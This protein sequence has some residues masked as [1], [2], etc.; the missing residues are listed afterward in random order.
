MYFS[1]ERRIVTTDF[2]TFVVLLVTPTYRAHLWISH[3]FLIPSN[4]RILQNNLQFARNICNFCSISIPQFYWIKKKN[5]Q[6]LSKAFDSYV[7]NF[8]LQLILGVYQLKLNFIKIS[9]LSDAS[10]A[11]VNFWPYGTIFEMPLNRNW[12]LCAVGLLNFYLIY[13]TSHIPILSFMILL[14]CNNILE[15]LI[16]YRFEQQ[17]IM[18]VLY[19][20]FW[21]AHICND[22]FLHH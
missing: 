8:R 22:R 15:C 6:R 2:S 19:I 1:V 20:C 10:F 5:F 12:L 11:E 3:H 13:P 7:K 14:E 16:R 21:R 4:S 9:A 17:I 18:E